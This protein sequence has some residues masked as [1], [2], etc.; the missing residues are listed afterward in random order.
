MLPLEADVD[1]VRAEVATPGRYRFDPI[2]DD[3]QADR[4]RAGRATCMVHELT[5]TRCA[6]EHRDRYAAADPSDNVVDRGDADERGDR[7]SVVD[8]FPQMME[9]AAVLLRA[10]DGAG[11][12]A[13]V[14]RWR[15][16]TASDDEDDGRR[17]Q[18]GR[19]RAGS[20]ST[21]CSRRSCR[22][23]SLGLAAAR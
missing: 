15:S 14:R 12:P 20:T 4:Q 6:R 13:R 9:A 10:A 17:G 8:R 16:R 21:R 5:P 2:D 19:A 1:D 3:E 23:S 11:L 18:R 7:A 22:S